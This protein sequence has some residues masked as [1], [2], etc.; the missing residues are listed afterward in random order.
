MLPFAGFS[1]QTSNFGRLR[2]IENTCFLLNRKHDARYP[3]RNKKRMKTRRTGN[4]WHVDQ[5]SLL[6]SE[7]PRRMGD[8]LGGGEAEVHEIGGGPEKLKEMTITKTGG[9]KKRRNLRVV[10]FNRMFFDFTHI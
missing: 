4:R 6:A 3:E 7:L 10:I 2:H 1:T 8:K 9:T 5:N